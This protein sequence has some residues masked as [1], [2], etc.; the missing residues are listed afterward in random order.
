MSEYQYYEFVAVD[1]PLTARRQAALRA[2]STRAEITT[3]SFTNYYNYGSFKGD[4][5]ALMSTYFD[6]H[7]Y[8]ALW[9]TRQLMFRLPVTALDPATAIRYNASSFK[10]RTHVVIDLV[11][12][13]EEGEVELES[14]GGGLLGAITPARAGLLAGD[15]RLLYLGWLL[16]VQLMRLDDDE[17]EPPVPA[18]LD[19]LDGPLTAAAAFLRLDPDLLTVAATGSAARAEPTAVQLTAWVGELPVAEKDALLTRAITGASIHGDL[20]RRYRAEHPDRAGAR[21]SRTAGMLRGSAEKARDERE[22]LDA[23]ARRQEQERRE[24]SAAAERQRHLDRLSRDQIRAWQRVFALIDT[25]TSRGYDEAVQLLIDLRDISERD[26][27]EAAFGQ[28]IAEL[29]AGHLS[30]PAFQRRLADVGLDL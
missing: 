27:A 13:D 22:R 11:F 19:R 9:G 15:L 23:A 2:I 10:T 26:S 14:E 21:A 7:L 25:K 1:R 6:A 17:P 18:G 20:L 5:R 12:Q 30:K 24:R 3:T 8:L 29:R 16:D 4:E 28:R